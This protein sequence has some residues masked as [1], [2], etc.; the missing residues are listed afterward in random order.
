MDNLK[1]LADKLQANMNDTML[2]VDKAFKALPI[3]ARSQMGSA[4]NDVNKIKSALSNGDDSV[5]TNIIK[6]YADTNK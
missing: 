4:M 1:E 3:E 5:I 6:K 2:L